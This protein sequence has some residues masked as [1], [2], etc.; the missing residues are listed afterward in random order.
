MA[1]FLDAFDDPNTAGLLSAAASILSASGPSTM[2]RS[3]GQVMGGGLLGYM[4]GRKQAL[5]QQKETMQMDLLK[6]QIAQATR[7]NNL[8]NSMLEQ[9]MGGGPA[10][11]AAEALATGAKAGDIGPTVSNAARIPASAPAA[12]LLSSIPREAVAHDIAFNDGKN[13]SE[14]LFK[15]GTPDMQVSNGYAYDK[16][17]VKPGFMPNLSVSQNGQATVTTIGPDGL[18][19]VS[20][21]KGA[22][23]TYSAYQDANEAAKAKYQT[24]TLPLPGGPRMVS[25]AQLPS[26]LGANGQSAGTSAE[27]VQALPPALQARV[28]YLKT[29][30]D[31]Q[32]RQSF[33]RAVNNNIAFAPASQRAQLKSMWE[34]AVSAQDTGPGVALQDD[35]EKKIATGRAEAQVEREK[36]RPGALTSLQSTVSN[37]DRLSSE[38]KAIMADPALGRITGFFGQFP[39]SPGSKA[40]DLSA[41]LE[42]LKSQVGFGVLQAMRDASKT[43]GALGSISDAEGKRLEN[44]LAALDKSQSPEAFKANLQQIVDYVDGTKSRLASAYKDTYGADFESPAAPKSKGWQDFGYANQQAALNDAKNVILRNPKMRGEVIKRLEL[45]GITNHGMK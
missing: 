6:Q 15:R 22:L 17:S 24:T 29:I 4:G 14:W 32:E 43:G 9:Y 5:D 37:L 26:L 18:P 16:N 38:A 23:D 31:P 3:L 40:S 30:A 10:P 11:G 27:P 13:I 35:A 44:N 36:E 33:I 12:G 45:M 2:P 28:D 21:P 19:V 34:S 1:G 20:A 42:T 7:K 39:N 8:V 25:N 41:R